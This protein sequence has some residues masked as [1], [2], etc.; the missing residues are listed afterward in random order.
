MGTTAIDPVT[1]AIKGTY[2]EFLKNQGIYQWKDVKNADP[3]QMNI[4]DWAATSEENYMKWALPQIQNKLMT[5]IWGNIHQQVQQS[6]GTQVLKRQEELSQN[7]TTYDDTEV[8]SDAQALRGEVPAAAQSAPAVQP[9]ADVEKKETTW[10]EQK[11]DKLHKELRAYNDKRKKAGLGWIRV[12]E[13]KRLK[14]E[15]K[16]K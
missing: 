11:R 5:G 14:K 8:T 15:G 4:P 13:Y 16:I 6:N 1:G 3:S 12:D 10:E 2:G 7:V 9:A